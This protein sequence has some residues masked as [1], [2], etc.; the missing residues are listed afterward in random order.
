MNVRCRY[1]M[2]AVFAAGVA[3]PLRSQAGRELTPEQRAAIAAGQDVFMTWPVNG[4]SWPR[5][6]VFRYVDATP[7]EAAAV[8]TE[9]EYHVAYIPE[10]T[11]A[12]IS[13]VIDPATVEVDYRLRVPIVADEDYTVRDHV[14][15]AGDTSF[16]V[17]WTLVRATT[18]KATDG[19][20]RF[21][22]YRGATTPQA[23][24]LMAYCNLV[25]PGSRL[26]GLHFIRSRALSQVRET[27]RAIGAEIVRQRASDPTR[28][29]AA[30]RA[31]RAA[32]AAPPA[33]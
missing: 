3:S 23:K 17:E 25:T 33:P 1:L 16:T 29:G 8:F 20:V 2:A 14:S 26:A 7:E 31:L 19:S 4:S 18:T 6:C 13:R 15:S 10:V 22:P 5:A 21:E 30:L 11:K 9:Y 32:L 24:T 27:A 12:K 28:L